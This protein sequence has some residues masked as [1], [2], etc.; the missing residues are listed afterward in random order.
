MKRKIGLFAFMSA[1]GFFITLFIQAGA[2]AETIRWRMATAFTPVITPYHESTLNLAKTIN[3]MS[4]GRLVITV[5]PAGEIVPP[6]EVFDATRKHAVE[7]AAA[8]STYWTTK[9]TAFD[10]ICSLGFMMTASDWITWLYNGGGLQLGQELYAKYG[11]KYFPVVIT[12]PESGFRMNKPIHTIADFK[13]VI[14]RTGVLQT[15]WILEQLGASPV[16]VSGGEIYMAL[17]LGTIDGAEMGGPAVDWNIKMQETTKYQMTPAGW[18]Q[19]STV[20]DFMINMDEWNKLPNDLKAI[21]EIA[22]R[23][24]MVW[25][26]EKVNWDTIGAVKNFEKAGIKESRL[27]KATLDKIEELAIK[28]I[29]NESAKNPDYAKIASLLS[30][31]SKGLMK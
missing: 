17:K 20:G 22:C 21:V 18:H 25:S 14:M 1:L 8:V 26:Y 27:D 10:L 6:F 28:F 4:G 2:T 15:I 29:E 3:E 19:I 7:A 24:N 9:N 5:H 31:I 16:R 23:A 11:L 12:G 13:G 30:T